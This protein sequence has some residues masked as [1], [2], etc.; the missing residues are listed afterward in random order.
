MCFKAIEILCFCT[1]HQNKIT[2]GLNKSLLAGNNWKS[3]KRK[4]D[5]RENDDNQREQ[6]SS[7]PLDVGLFVVESCRPL[8]N[9]SRLKN[10]SHP[11]FDDTM[12]AA[13]FCFEHFEN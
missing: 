12:K 8:G 9:F 11:I 6:E 7:V 10:S 2:P 4:G 5:A 1:L 13:S 3:N